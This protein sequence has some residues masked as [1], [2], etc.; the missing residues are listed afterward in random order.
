MS[1]ENEL[2]SFGKFIHGIIPDELRVNPYNSE[3]QPHPSLERS[4]FSLREYLRNN[5]SQSI[6]GEVVDE[7]EEGEE[8]IAEVVEEEVEEQERQSIPL[9]IE[10]QH[11]SVQDSVIEEVEDDEQGNIVE[12]VSNPISGFGSFMYDIYQSAA[13][14]P[15]PRR[16]S[17][18]RVQYVYDYYRRMINLIQSAQKPVP[19]SEEALSSLLIVI[20]Y[21]YDI[22]FCR[23]SLF[24]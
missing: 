1:V 3:I 2:T 10:E 14:A 13:Y 6:G 15:L 4:S 23:T 9:P 8:G 16:D 17:Q 19:A 24:Q 22:L 20:C 5:S 12:V 7:G 21:S 11:N 18:S